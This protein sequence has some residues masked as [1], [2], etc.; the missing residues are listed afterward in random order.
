MI[1]PGKILELDHPYL[2]DYPPYYSLGHYY[3]KLKYNINIRNIENE[4]RRLIIYNH[5][6]YE[7]I[8]IQNYFGFVPRI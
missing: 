3:S 6:L 2:Y 1:K 4:V 5:L 7:W 8:T